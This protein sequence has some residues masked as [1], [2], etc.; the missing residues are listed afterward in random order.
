MCLKFARHRLV[1]IEATGI[2]LVNVSILN[3]PIDV[4]CIV[5]AASLTDAL[6]GCT[7]YGAEAATI[8]IALGVVCI[9]CSNST[10]KASEIELVEVSTR[11]RNGRVLGRHIFILVAT[12]VK[13]LEP[14]VTTYKIIGY[15]V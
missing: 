13:F 7:A 15:L 1:A 9:A 6:H 12:Q 4:T 11:D 5:G 10:I 8:D 2:E 3:L 14:Y